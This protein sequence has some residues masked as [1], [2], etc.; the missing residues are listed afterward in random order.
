MSSKKPDS[1]GLY[2]PAAGSDSCGVGFITRK[3]GEQTHE[4]LRMAHSALCT[5]PHRG[6]MSAEG[7]G[8]GAGVNV[9]LSLHFFRKIT[10]QALEAGRFGVGNF[11]VPKDTE[12]RANAERL[13]EETL[14]R[15]NL[16]VILK[17]E[18]PLDNSV[19]RPA[20]M[21][22]QLPIVQWI[23][24]APQDISNQSDFEKLIYRALLT[25]EAQ[26]FTQTEFG[27]LYPLSLSSRTQVFKARL[28]SNEVIPYF[29]DLTDPDHHVRG[30][31]FP[32][33]LLNQ[34]RSAHH[35]GT[36]FPVDGPQR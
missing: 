23:F 11:F 28:N 30:L 7:V 2:D 36:A 10:G 18:M 14:N 4:I 17:R 13:V 27:G 3:D 25:I 16:P 12:L 31:F 22:F 1:Y 9:D 8:D 20:A 35:H 5:V 21:Q 32:Y 26:A 33:S 6:G 15:F 34:Y 29:K 24:A 19:T